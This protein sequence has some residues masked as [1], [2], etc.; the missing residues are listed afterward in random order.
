MSARIWAELGG[1]RLQ[2]RAERSLDLV[3]GGRDERFEV[4][5]GRIGVAAGLF[6]RADGE[7]QGVLHADEVAAGVVAFVLQG[8]DE[9]AGA[10]GRSRELGVLGDLVGSG[11]G[12]VD[13]E[14]RHAD[15]RQHGQSE[16]T[17]QLQSDRDPHRFPLH[18]V[19]FPLIIGRSD[20]RN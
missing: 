8:D 1:Q 16:R 18:T 12:P 9:A 4:V 15:E 6:D 11:I 19:G 17:C 2:P 3:P 14:E 13:L 5:S 10:H 20:S 7:H